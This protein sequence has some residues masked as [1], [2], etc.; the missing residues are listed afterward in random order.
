MKKLIS[1]ILTALM[2]LCCT[3]C[4]PNNNG[5]GSSADVVYDKANAGYTVHAYPSGV[6]AL[7]QNIIVD[8][9]FT[10]GVKLYGTV[11]TSVLSGKYLTYGDTVDTSK[12]RWCL[13]E[14]SSKSTLANASGNNY[15]YSKSGN[16][17]T[18]KDD[19]KLVAINPVD[20]TATLRVNAIKEYGNA[21][22][23]LAGTG[24]NNWAHLLLQGASDMTKL[25]TFTDMKVY[26][27]FKI[28]EVTKSTAFTPTVPGEQAAQFVFYLRLLN[29]KTGVWTWFGIPLYDNREEDD[30]FVY[31]EMFMWD[32]ATKSTIYNIPK[33]MYFNTQP[34]VGTRYKKLIDVGQYLNY[35]FEKSIEIGIYPAGTTKDDVVIQFNN[36]G[37]EVLGTMDCQATIYGL[38]CYIL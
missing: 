7:A 4:A 20:G 27:D 13:S 29:Q 24:T 8:N 2:V 26:I 32:I 28:D 34:V 12:T 38:G 23:P 16:T 19:Y 14:W 25:S 22:R 21:E 9:K 36:I 1:I 3:A 37:W 10:Q 33:D 11:S 31:G 6:N 18:Y 30:P 17:H 35:L 5:A 15:S